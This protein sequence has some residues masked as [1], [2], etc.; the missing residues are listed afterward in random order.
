MDSF[1]S[2]SF[3]S[4]VD[5]FSLCVIPDPLAALKEMARVVRPGGRVLLLEHAR[6]DNPLL[7]L[8]QVRPGG[9]RVRRLL[10]QRDVC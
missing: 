6:S 9:Q 1:A 2:S 3:D 5:S 7:G 8:Y 4:V 10:R